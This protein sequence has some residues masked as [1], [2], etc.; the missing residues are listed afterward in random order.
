M[1]GKRHPRTTALTTK[2]ARNARRHFPAWNERL[3]TAGRNWWKRWAA[4]A[5]GSAGLHHVTTWTKGYP[6]MLTCQPPNGFPE[7]RRCLLSQFPTPTEAAPEVSV[8]A[9]DRR[10]IENFW[11]NFNILWKQKIH[12]K[13]TPTKMCSPT[14]RGTTNQS[15][16]RKC[17]KT[18]FILK[19]ENWDAFISKRAQIIVLCFTAKWVCGVEPTIS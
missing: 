11:E 18:L 19:C 16:L 12:T 1:A 6:I 8:F 5:P 3:A 4:P 7:V 15:V 9:G 13:E 14:C 2:R 10:S 17:S